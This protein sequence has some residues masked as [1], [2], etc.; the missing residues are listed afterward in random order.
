MQ[1]GHVNDVTMN[2][3]PFFWEGRIFVNGAYF[4]CV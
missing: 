4:F 2:I 1:I 3:L